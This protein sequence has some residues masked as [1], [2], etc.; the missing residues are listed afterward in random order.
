MEAITGHVGA[1]H[2]ALNLTAFNAANRL[3]SGTLDSTEWVLPRSRRLRE[4]QVSSNLSI[5]VTNSL[6]VG[7][8]LKILHG[9]ARGWDLML[10]RSP[11]MKHGF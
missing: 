3:G 5:R 2:L 1:C 9:H 7:M 10:Y 4:L 8:L 11:R 6:I